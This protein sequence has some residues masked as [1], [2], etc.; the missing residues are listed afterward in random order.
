M[1]PKKTRRAVIYARISIASEKSVSVARQLESAKLYA[2]ARGWKVVGEPYVDDGVSASKNKPED[3]KGWQSL[4]A[5][6]DDYDTV[7]I[8]K[9]DRLARRVMDFHTANEALKER[10]A[11]LVAVE[12]SIDMATSDGKLIANVLASFAEYEA[13]AIATRVKAARD[14]LLRSGRHAGGAVL[15][16]YKA[17]SNPDG[18]GYVVVQ[19]EDR[20]GYVRTMTERTLAGLSLY[21]TMAWLNEVGAPTYT[22]GDKWSYTTVERIVRHPLLAGMV[23]HN[24]GYT[25]KYKERG[26]DVVRDE[27]GLPIIDESL[28]IMPVGQWRAMVTRLDAPGKDNRRM[29]R[30]MRRKTSG[31]LSGLMFCGE[32]D[33]P[34]RMWRGTTQGRPSY[35]CKECKQTLSAAQE[36]ILEEFLTQRGDVTHLSFVEEVVE[37]GSVQHREATVRIA[38]LG[39]EIVNAAPERTVE[40]MVELARLK[41]MQ[42]EAKDAPAETIFRPVGGESR[43]Y[44]EDWAAA[45]DDE[46]RRTILGHALDRI[47]V[48][49]GRPGAWTPAA[50]LARLTFE[51]KDAGQVEPPTDAELA[52]WAEYNP[53]PA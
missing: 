25:A 38:E 30:A 2:Q 42:E 40:I 19:D 52:A 3:R 1:S 15:Y 45:T 27:D 31:V 46:Q 53:V 41:E 36:L 12:N 4:V 6:R 48:R 10:G 34:T 14:Y 44:A 22:G 17:V 50:K 9:L 28:A 33:E 37:G 16:G 24:P 29:P 39:R 23:L 49:R 32:H 21:S 13:D 51:W 47:V 35:I 18:P 20:I 7:I 5:S 11:A 43:S 8:W 26:D